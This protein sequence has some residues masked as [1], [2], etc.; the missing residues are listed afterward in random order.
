M[1]Y[2]L[3]IAN[4]FINKSIQTGDEITPMKL[5]KLVYIS[6]GW[7]LA[8]SGEPLLNEKVQAWKYGPVVSSVYH[9]FKRYGVSNIDK[10]EVGD[11]GEL[12]IVK[13]PDVAGFLDKIWELYGK[14]N[15]VQLSALTHQTDTPWYEVWYK[16]G[17]STNPHS[18]IPDDLIEEHYKAK[19][20]PDA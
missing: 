5:V 18:Q 15:G 3:E 10:L 8:L 13:D 2:P 14:M 17:G 12:L 16:R 1:K 4:Y 19:L 11:F 20:L 7:H 9:R 6:H